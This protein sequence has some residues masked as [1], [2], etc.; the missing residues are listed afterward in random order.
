MKAIVLTYDKYHPVTDHMIH[1]YNKLWPSNP[2]AFRIPYEKYP[3]SLADKYGDKVE[4]MPKKMGVDPR[5]I[6]FTVLFLLEDIHDDQW[7]YWC[8]DDRYLETIKEDELN[9]MYNWIYN[10]EDPK[11]SGISFCRYRELIDEQYIY[12]D[13]KITNKHNQ[14][15][16]RRKDYIQIYSHQFLRAKV[17]KYLFR[18]FPDRPFNPHEMDEF[19]K[20][21]YLP[22]NHKLYVS[23]KNYV[24]F[25]ESTSRGQ[26]TK[27]CAK[28]FFRWG[29]DIP[30]NFEISDKIKVKGAI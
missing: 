16:I 17:L 7:I 10:I 28:S 26:L 20:K 8:M 1:S 11:I 3:Y 21:R 30:T 2:F 12:T 24:V 25:G 14:V 15:F 29:I 9:N 4:L 5:L 18:S 13:Q 23:E 6:K 27:N 22:G 19:I